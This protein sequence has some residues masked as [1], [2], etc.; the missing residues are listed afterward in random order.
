[1]SELTLTSENF[2][3]T[4]NSE[5]PTIVDFWASWCMPCRMMAPVFESLSTKY[6]STKLKFG[7]VSTEEEQE[8]AGQNNIS[9]IPC[10]VVY[11]K[12]KEIGRIVGLAAEDVLKKK[13]DSIIG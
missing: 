5:V 13:I 9:G 12:G 4:I 3:Q 7:K 10:L 2:K 8:L 6:P 11:K 1:M